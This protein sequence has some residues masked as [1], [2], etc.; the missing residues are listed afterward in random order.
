MWQESG[1]EGLVQRPADGRG[2]GGRH[3]EGTCTSVTTA[4]DAVG[5]SRRAGLRSG[6]G[7]LA[8]GGHPGQRRGL[9]EAGG[10]DGETP[11]GGAHAIPAGALREKDGGRHT[12]QGPSGA[13]LD[14]P[15]KQKTERDSREPCLLETSHPKH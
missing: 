12:R 5:L 9:G 3:G 4:A 6:S 2:G 10:G 13:A 14:L 1:R 7:A 11:V 15:P 8:G